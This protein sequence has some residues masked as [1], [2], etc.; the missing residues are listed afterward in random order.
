MAW[1]LDLNHAYVSRSGVF[2]VICQGKIQTHTV[3]FYPIQIFKSG[4]GAEP[5][6]IFL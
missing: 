4:G 1:D 6:D 2:R 5:N 3:S